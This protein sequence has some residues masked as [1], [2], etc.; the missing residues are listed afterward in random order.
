MPPVNSKK[1]LNETSRKHKSLTAA[2]KKKICLKK[3]ITPYIKQKELATQ[4]DVS[5]GMISN[6]LKKR[7]R[8]LVIDLNS[9]QADLRREKKVAFPDIEEALT[10]WVYN[11]IQNNLTITDN[12]LS[13]KHWDLLFCLRKINLKAPTDE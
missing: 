5:K 11:A 1:Q 13:T 9:L 3:A 10:I 6:I 4:Y 8:W 12:I 7:N 2:Q